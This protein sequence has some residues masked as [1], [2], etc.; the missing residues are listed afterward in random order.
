MNP[1]IRKIQKLLR[2]AD[3]QAGRPEGELA[4]EKAAKLM[5]DHAVAMADLP[6]D[7]ADAIDPDVPK[8]FF[9]VGKGWRIH[10]AWA[11]AQHCNVYALRA[12]RNYCCNTDS[13]PKAW[14]DMTKRERKQ[15]RFVY[16]Y[17]CGKQSDIEVFEYLYV[18][19][20]RQIMAAAKAYAKTDDARHL[21]YWRDYNGEWQTSAGAVDRRQVNAFKDSAVRGLKSKLEAMRRDIQ[22]EDEQGWGL[23]SNRMTH[24]RSLYKGTTSTF[25]STRR[26]NQSGYDA[27]RKVSLNAGVRGGSSA[28]RIPR[29]HRIGVK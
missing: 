24:A 14:E 23:V 9:E 7:E 26:Y 6:A 11:L 27:G 21:Q 3:D 22:A 19:C 13:T 28:R 15:Q 1:I 10:L 20:E 16:A 18:V 8:Y 25:K 4:A 17:L 2:L 12:Q 5:R 29:T